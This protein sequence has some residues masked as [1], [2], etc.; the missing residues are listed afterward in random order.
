MADV[1]CVDCQQAVW[2]CVCSQLAAPSEAQRQVSEDESAATCNDS[3]QVREAAARIRELEAGLS[4]SVGYLLNAKIDLETGATKATAIRTIEGG[5]ARARAL[6]G[7]R[8][9]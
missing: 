2:G 4:A 1:L 8:G 7:E 5:I 6:L 9:E 3:L